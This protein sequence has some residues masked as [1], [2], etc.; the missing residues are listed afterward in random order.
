MDD[1]EG[2]ELESTRWAKVISSE[3]ERWPG[4]GRV[5]EGGGWRYL[6]QCWPGVKGD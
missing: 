6:V 5:W 2:K 3:G 4:A 1:V